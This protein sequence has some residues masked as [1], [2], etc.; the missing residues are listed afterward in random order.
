MATPT[1]ELSHIG[2][3]SGTVVLY[4]AVIEML[5]FSKHY[6]HRRRTTAAGVAMATALFDIKLLGERERAHHYVIVLIAFLYA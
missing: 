5:T 6:L 3:L 2:I 1:I 4:L